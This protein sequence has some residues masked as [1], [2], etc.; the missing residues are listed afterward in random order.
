MG[1]LVQVPRS[2]LQQSV[3][4]VSKTPLVKQYSLVLLRND[5]L[6]QLLLPHENITRNGRKIFHGYIMMKNTKV[7]FVRVVE[8]QRHRIRFHKEVVVYGLQGHSE[9]KKGNSK[10]EGTCNQ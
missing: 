5:V 4:T 9:M 7:H 2:L 3:V 6:D 10:D 1:F 8:C